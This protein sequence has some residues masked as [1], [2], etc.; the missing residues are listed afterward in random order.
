M[1]I[2]L[3]IDYNVPLPWRQPIFFFIF[4]DFCLYGLMVIGH[5]H[6]LS[7]NFFFFGFFLNMNM[8]CPDY[9]AFIGQRICLYVPVIYV[10]I[11]L[12]SWPQ[13]KLK[14]KMLCHSLTLCKMAICHWGLICMLNIGLNLVKDFQSYSKRSF[15]SLRL[16]FVWFAECRAL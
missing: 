3:K 10:N 16:A 1:D 8:H 2:C 9:L 7:L 12:V 6:V 15:Q 11:G 13:R 4:I 14:S 5:F